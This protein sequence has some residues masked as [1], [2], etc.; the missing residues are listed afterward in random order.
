MN[1]YRD[2]APPQGDLC[3]RCELG[4]TPR[5]VADVT[6]DECQRCGGVFVPGGL[7]P[8]FLDG[9]DLGG[10]VMA[11]FPPGTPANDERGPLY[12][13]CPKCSARMHRRLFAKRAK[14]ILDIC[15]QHGMWFD[16]HELRA[17][18][19]FGSRGGTPELGDAP[20]LAPRVAD[21]GLDDEEDPDRPN[22]LQSAIL[23]ILDAFGL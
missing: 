13:K 7:I 8:R 18:A 23:W 4:L 5:Q 11:T 9:L 15:R 17:I 20:A 16:A 3:P 10:E 21:R 12:V 2:S 1:P 19:V 6:I 22:H 14:V